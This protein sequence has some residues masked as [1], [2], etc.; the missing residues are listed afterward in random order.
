MAISDDLRSL[1]T[2]LENIPGLSK[3]SLPFIELV[4][5]NIQALADQVES[6]EN[7]PL[8]LGD[9]LLADSFNHCRAS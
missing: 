9:F 1:Q 3:E 8:A 6:L 2:A 7:T 4:N 5:E